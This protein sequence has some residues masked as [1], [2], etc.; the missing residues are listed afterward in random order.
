[1]AAFP[2]VVRWWPSTQQHQRKRGGMPTNLQQRPYITTEEFEAVINAIVVGLARVAI[3]T[4]HGYQDRER[5]AADLERDIERTKTEG[6]E[7]IAVAS[8]LDLLATSV[9]EGTVPNPD[10]KGP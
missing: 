4:C 6:A 8:V 2:P 5:L 3:S 1:M 9:R 10:W 7:R